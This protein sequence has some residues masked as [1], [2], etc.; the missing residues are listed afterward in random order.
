V[1]YLEKRLAPDWEKLPEPLH[2]LIH[3]AEKYGIYLADAAMIN[4]LQHKAT[5]EDLNELATTA[6]RIRVNGDYERIIQWLKQYSM[7]DHREAY[8][9]SNLVGVMDY[10]DLDFA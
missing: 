7:V 2:Y 1:G 4:F 10:A 8:L 3:P 5:A 6:E 9:V